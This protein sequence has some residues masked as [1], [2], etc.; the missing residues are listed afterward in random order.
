MALIKCKQCGNLI[1][2]KA[3]RC[4]KCGCLITKEKPV[5][6]E[7]PQLQPIY[8]KEENKANSKKTLYAIICVLI[9]ALVGVGV[10]IWKAGSVSDNVVSR[11][12]SDGSIDDMKARNLD[13]T[14]LLR[15]SVG[16]YGAEM[17]ITISGNAVSGQYHYDSLNSNARMLLNG[18]LKEDG[19]LIMNE[20]APNG[21][22]SGRFDGDFDGK[23]FSG[24]FYNLINGK[25]FSFSFSP[26]S[27]LYDEKNNNE[28]YS[29]INEGS[30]D[31]YNKENDHVAVVNCSF[32]GNQ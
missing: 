5:T 17:S 27:T 14:Y 13:G 29:D 6:Q 21:K 11:N 2:D 12:V 25:Q 24:T 32:T 30:F 20:R 3:V 31:V 23:M 8:Y 16:A 28:A 4:P 19:T 9:A 15:G 22:M 7:S 1:S 26:T 10:W 18:T